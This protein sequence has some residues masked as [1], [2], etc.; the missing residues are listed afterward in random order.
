MI[1][2]DVKQYLQGYVDYITIMNCVDFKLAW[3]KQLREFSICVRNSPGVD[4][5]NK[6]SR[7]MTFEMAD[8]SNECIINIVFKLKEFMPPWHAYPSVF[9]N[10]T[11]MYEEKKILVQETGTNSFRIKIKELEDLQDFL[12]MLHDEK[13]YEKWDM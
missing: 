5:V 2:K 12:Q 1:Y 6:Y 4:H 7:I 11:I 9:E 10:M 3:D 8:I 13:Y